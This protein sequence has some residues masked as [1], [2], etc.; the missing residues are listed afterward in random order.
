MSPLFPFDVGFHH[1]G[2]FGGHAGSNTSPV[3]NTN[4]LNNTIKYHIMVIWLISSVAGIRYSRVT[5]KLLRF[6]Y[7][8]SLDMVPKNF[9]FNLIYFEISYLTAIIFDE[10][11]ITIWA[12]NTKKYWSILI[13]N[14]HGG[15]L[16]Q[17]FNYLLL[18]LSPLANAALEVLLSLSIIKCQMIDLII[19][20]TFAVQYTYHMHAR[21]YRPFF[22]LLVGLH[23]WGWQRNNTILRFA[24]QTQ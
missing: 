7:T 13:T 16:P 14:T 6:I 10:T 9:F 15:F 4:N 18:L 21:W 3:L 2:W 12:T 11:R 22:L 23:P 24:T 8:F 19:I 5:H 1:L 20:I 17:I